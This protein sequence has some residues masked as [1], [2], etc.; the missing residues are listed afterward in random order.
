MTR[1][2]LS[3]VLVLLAFSPHAQVSGRGFRV[4]A[5]AETGDR[6]QPSVDA[7]KKWLTAQAEKNSFKIDFI[8][9]P[10]P[11][12]DRFLSRYQLFIQLN[13]PPYRWSDT[14]KIAFQK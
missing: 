7:A 1:L 4:I 13:Y 6:H 11:I 10:D 14:A 3:G 12:N 5:L 9:S 8:D 2:F